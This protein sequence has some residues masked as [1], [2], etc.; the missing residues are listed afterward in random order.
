MAIETRKWLLNAHLAKVYQFP[1][2]TSE[3]S[4]VP[5]SEHYDVEDDLHTDSYAET[6]PESYESSDWD[7]SHD[8]FN[9]GYKEGKEEGF[10]SGL[11]AGEEEGKK[12]GYA[13]GIRQGR[14][15]GFLQSKHDVDN[16][17][18]EVMVP[19]MALKSLLEEGYHNQI[20]QQQQL[21]VDLVRRITKQ[22]IRCELTLQPQQILTLVE[23]TIASLPTD[24]SEI[25]IHL[26][27]SAVKELQL[28]AFDKLK[29]WKIVADPEISSGGC[30]IV[31]NKCD[32]DASVETRLNA[33]I[34]KV[35][36]HLLSTN[37]VNET[38]APN[39]ADVA[40]DIAKTPQEVSSNETQVNNAQ[41]QE[42][43]PL[44]LESSVD[45]H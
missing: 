25:E 14:E 12:I 7:D 37:S 9:K 31:T 18:M 34:D 27:P 38:T 6:P 43:A 3:Q 33:C 39:N 10:Q 40:S 45:A 21:I 1:P 8:V 26:E 41:H 44:E 2:L 30:R 42:N 16:K 13:E 23:E 19:L 17:L 36:E 35:E 24:A 11:F 32:A 15:E 28:L 5:S 20:N 4:V 29:D 22:V